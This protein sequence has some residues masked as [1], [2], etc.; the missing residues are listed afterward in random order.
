[1]GAGEATIV[2]HPWRALGVC[3][4][5]LIATAGPARALQTEIQQYYDAMT[6][7]CRTGVTPPMMAAWERAQQALDAARDGGGQGGV[8]FAGIKRPDHAW[9]DCFQSPGDGKE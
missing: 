6:D 4:A 2:R 3:I 7:V 8:N 5:V 9:L 1:V